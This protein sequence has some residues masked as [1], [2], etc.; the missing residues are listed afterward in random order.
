[1]ANSDDFTVPV[2]IVLKQDDMNKFVDS[3]KKGKKAIDDFDGKTRELQKDITT[4]MDKVVDGTII[5]NKKVLDQNIKTTKSI[6]NGVKTIT[7]TIRNNIT[8]TT[9]A[10]IMQQKVLGN[11]QKM[12]NRLSDEK[13]KIE[14]RLEDQK[15]K[16]IQQSSKAQL[17]Y[18][19]DLERKKIDQFG[20]TI[21][22]QRS[23]MEG[24][25][26]YTAH[27]AMRF[28]TFYAIFK[29]GDIVKDLTFGFDEYV[30]S[31]RK[32]ADTTGLT[33]EELQKLTYSARINLITQEQFVRYIDFM[34]KAVDEF[35]KNVGDAPAAFK[36]LKITLADIR[37]A[38]PA[39]VF[40]MVVDALS[41]ETDQTIKATA[42]KS[43]F[44]R[45]G[46]DVIAMAKDGAE[47]IKKQGEAYKEFGGIISDKTLIQSMQNIL[48]W[49]EKIA[50][51]QA[52]GRMVG[53]EYTE[54]LQGLRIFT[55]NYTEAEKKYSEVQTE[56]I[57]REIKIV[58]LN[59]NLAKE[60]GK[61]LNIK[62][63][64]K[65]I[66]QSDA[67]YNK[68]YSKDIEK[69]QA[70]VNKLRK[71]LEEENNVLIKL[72]PI[73]EDEAR[74]I[75]ILSDKKKEETKK[76]VDLNTEYKNLLDTIS[77]T[78]TYDELI[79]KLKG[80]KLSG[81]EVD[82]TLKNLGIST[83]EFVDQT[84]D[85]K[86]LAKALE[87]LDNLIESEKNIIKFNEAMAKMNKEAEFETYIQ[88]F[89][90]L[91]KEIEELDK[92]T[93]ELLSKQLDE[94][95]DSFSATS[96]WK[97]GEG[98][99]GVDTRTNEE[100][101]AED[102][103]SHE[104]WGMTEFNDKV[105]KNIRKNADEAEARNNSMWE[106]FKKGGKSAWQE[107]FEK[108]GVWNEETK[109]WENKMST[110]FETLGGQISGLL[111]NGIQQFGDAIG[112][113]V[114]NGGKLGDVLKEILKQML[115]N[116][117]SIIAQALIFL[118][119]MTLMNLI[120]PNSGT[121]FSGAIA[122]MTGGLT[123]GSF[124]MSSFNKDSDSA[125]GSFM[126]GFMGKAGGAAFGG[127]FGGGMGAF[128]D[129]GGFAGLGAGSL[130]KIPQAAHGMVTYGTKPIP[131][132]LHPNEVVLPAS[133]IKDF[134]GTMG[135]KLFSGQY[136]PSMKSGGGSMG[137]V[138][139]QLNIGAG[140]YESEKFWRTTT[141]K[142]IVPA[143]NEVMY[144]RV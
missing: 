80:M 23:M 103:K 143:I 119:I 10:E 31:L 13:F 136:I 88:H 9:D 14:K 118:G 68:Q 25:A 122:A 61:L 21:N 42:A 97:P 44:A 81:D 55:G 96:K 52:I 93:D 123:Q 132:I 34:N 4:Y 126:S 116:I 40:Y 110:T 26:Q 75:G 56:I 46:R 28:A 7:K 38:S 73:R 135:A 111:V 11:L 114:V 50:Q 133:Y 2:K 99:G 138:S 54:T 94:I 39:E 35:K 117:I 124:D 82:Q 125:K 112:N 5:A 107:Q 84:V 77:Y 70:T 113:A 76:T 106:R 18:Y 66:F 51:A 140:N 74:K 120:V 58:D 37:N 17:K 6:E 92:N 102:R 41:K 69:Q 49:Q 33:T 36:S 105:F 95:I 128:F 129:K 141:R 65:V 64:K 121:A 115:A 127:L 63:K 100:R 45:E 60:E 131:A 72:K 144:G 3:M 79:D 71:E 78:A 12:R 29:I 32:A 8:Q 86:K 20:N 85:P 83:K 53:K 48:W 19:S 91:N 47:A 139:I 67:E 59:K 24:F 89:K 142:Y 130:P 22:Q 62:D 27:W 1:M 137:S 101:S 90:D 104:D 57:D 108:Y 16:Q 109:Q 15:L 87:A 98:E 134:F 43:I 30:R